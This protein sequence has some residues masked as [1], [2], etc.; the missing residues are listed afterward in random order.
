MRYLTRLPDNFTRFYIVAQD[1]SISIPQSLEL[2][3]QS[4]LLRLW[5]LSPVTDLIN[6][7]HVLNLQ[8]RRI[9]RRPAL[10]ATP[11]HDIYFVEVYS[12]DPLP[13]QKDRIE[14]SIERARNLGALIDLVGMW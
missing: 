14:E 8:V 6:T 3:K 5:P 2:S 11:F 10:D 4:A 9:D 7:L 12:K 1:S 13:S